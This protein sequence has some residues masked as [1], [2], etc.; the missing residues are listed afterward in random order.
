[1]LEVASTHVFIPGRSLIERFTV[2][3]D[4]RKL[5]REVSFFEVILQ[6]DPT[7]QGLVLAVQ[8]VNVAEPGEVINAE[9]ENVFLVLCKS[10][11]HVHS[12]VSTSGARFG[13]GFK[14]G[15]PGLSKCASRTFRI[16]T[17]LKTKHSAKFVEV[18]VTI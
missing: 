14:S 17:S 2:R 10:N 13:C 15:D 8:H 9:L 1:M 5:G 18:K 4:E 11:V 16:R 12:M 6:V 3:F 7:H